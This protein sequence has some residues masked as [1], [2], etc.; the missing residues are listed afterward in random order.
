MP[1]LPKNLVKN[2][3]RPPVFDNPLRRTAS[4]A[5]ADT[6][7]APQS[8]PEAGEAQSEQGSNGIVIPFAGSPVD[9]GPEPTGTRPE[10]A[11]AENDHRIT[12]RIDDETRCALETE[13]HRR[14]IA[15]EKAKVAE[16]ARSVLTQWARRMARRMETSSSANAPARPDIGQ[17]PPS[18]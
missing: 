13:C 11:P 5:I 10:P 3:A 6:S 18:T 2:M 12:V 7:T 1:P 9:A 17:P 8:R 16:I 15:G 14:R 4:P